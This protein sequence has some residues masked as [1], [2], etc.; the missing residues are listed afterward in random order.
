MR[1]ERYKEVL[2]GTCFTQ[3]LLCIQ[4][5]LPEDVVGADSIMFKIQVDTFMDRKGLER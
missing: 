3:R 2:R 4:N 5:K 1:K